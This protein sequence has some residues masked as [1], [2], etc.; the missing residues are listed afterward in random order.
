MGHHKGKSKNGRQKKTQHAKGQKWR[1]QDAQERLQELQDRTSKVLALAKNM[2]QVITAVTP[3][4]GHSMRG[5]D[6]VM[7]TKLLESGHDHLFMMRD[8]LTLDP[9]PDYVRLN[10]ANPSVSTFLSCYTSYGQKKSWSGLSDA[11]CYRVPQFQCGGLPDATPAE[12][13]FSTLHSAHATTQQKA[14]A[15]AVLGKLQEEF[16]LTPTC[17]KAHWIKVTISGVE[18]GWMSGQC[19]RKNEISPE[20]FWGVAEERDACAN[21]HLI[22]C[23]CAGAVPSDDVALLGGLLCRMC[24]PLA[25]LGN[26]QGTPRK[27]LTQL[28]DR[29]QVHAV[30][31]LKR[32][33]PW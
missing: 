29:K 18:V 4:L 1:K 11:E 13:A 19:P 12:D 9:L 10:C 2:G 8:V 5:S 7:P 25:T 31:I 20:M 16:G 28:M 23:G 14:D 26:L 15:L 21:P 3:E 30:E 6:V 32:L 17:P 33:A 27:F 22:A 24:G